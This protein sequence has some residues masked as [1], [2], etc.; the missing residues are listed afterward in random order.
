MHLS[1]CVWKGPQELNIVHKLSS[2]YP[3][4]SA[5]F[6]T[7]LKLGNAT[8]DHIIKELQTVTSDTSFDTLRQ[9][10]LLLNGYLTLETLPSR[11]SE[12]EG[13]KII[14]VTTPSGEVRMDYDKNIWYL[15]D[16]TSLWE[17][18]KGK[19]PLIAFDDVRT[20]RT[21]KPLI[22]AMKVS[23]HILSEAV[24]QTLE[25]VGL[26]IKDEERTTDLRERAQ[27]FVQ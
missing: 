9:L 21:L 3:R 4:Y 6:R 19:I 1:D 14:P 15:A 13:K 23:S 22:N 11:I 2:E 27:Y 17:R 12:L 24:N 5:F 8:L 16:K 10:L 26:K 20:V 18:F 25:I 7:S